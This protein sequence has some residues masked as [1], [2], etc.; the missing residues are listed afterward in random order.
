MYQDLP[1]PFCEVKG[2]ARIVCVRRGR[3]WEHIDPEIPMQFS[4][5]HDSHPVCV[6]ATTFPGHCEKCRSSYWQHCCLQIPMPTYLPYQYIMARYWTTLFNH[7]ATDCNNICTE[8]KRI[9]WST[10]F[11]VFQFTWEGEEGWYS[12]YPAYP[13]RV[14]TEEKPYLIRNSHNANISCL[15]K[16]Y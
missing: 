9:S 6:T 12:S 3:A 10:C 2:H 15:L 14:K 11:T 4:F 16:A 8:R 7:N 5:W 13:L 1:P